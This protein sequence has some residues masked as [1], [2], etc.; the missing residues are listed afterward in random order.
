MARRA[1]NSPPA[2]VSWAPNRL[3]IFGLGV[4]NDM[5]HNWSSDGTNWGGWESLGGTF[6][7]P[8]AAVSWAPNRLDIFGLGVNNEMP[9][10]S[11]DG[12]GWRPSPADLTPLGGIL[13]SPPA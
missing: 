9:H 3:D 12:T 6:N 10:K 1:F 11:S 13:P 5:F 4:A 7:S 8:P 2:A